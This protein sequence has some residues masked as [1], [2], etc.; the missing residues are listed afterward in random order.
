M[1]SFPFTFRHWRARLRT[2]MSHGRAGWTAWLIVALLCVQMW[3][4]Q[5]E[6]VHARQLAGGA[7]STA[8]VNAD[9]E[10]D[11][12]AQTAWTP[13]SARLVHVDYGS[14]HHHCHLFEGATL[15]AAMA[16]AVLA[17]R[18]DITAALAPSFAIGRSHNS[19]LALA[20][21]SRAPPVPV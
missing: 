8:V 14:H 11:A 21:R 7:A 10:D 18:A 12:D 17:W 16:V 15:G 5:H 3:G 2:R 13:A 20:F 9:P 6:I 19:A 4:L 1:P